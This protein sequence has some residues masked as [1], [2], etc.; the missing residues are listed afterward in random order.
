MFVLTPFFLQFVL[1]P[2]KLFFSSVNI[3]L[4]Q[5]FWIILKKKRT[6]PTAIFLE[7]K[8]ANKVSISS[9]ALLSV[10]SFF[11]VV[12]QMWGL[13]I[14]FFLSARWFGKV[15]FLNSL[16]KRSMGFFSKIL[17]KKKPC[18][19]FILRATFLSV[20]NPF[21]ELFWC[22]AYKFCF[23]FSAKQDG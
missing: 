22:G 4:T 21:F 2:F 10:S 11:F 15:F 23:I 16:H 18:Y 12:F 20:I 5:I 6:W 7:N 9:S 1:W 19:T 3:V 17:R 14:C 13:E 8:R